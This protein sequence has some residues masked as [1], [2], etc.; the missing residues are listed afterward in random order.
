M[1]LHDMELNRLV[2][3]FAV[4]SHYSMNFLK[5]FLCVRILPCFCLIFF[6]KY[7]LYS[8]GKLIKSEGSFQAEVL[9]CK[10]LFVVSLLSIHITHISLL[11]FHIF[12][13]SYNDTVV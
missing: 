13:I 3:S 11:L 4:E 8:R 2:S 7:G 1:F 10:G 9:R 5:Q 6:F 12:N